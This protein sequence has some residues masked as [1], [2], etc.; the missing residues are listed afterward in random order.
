MVRSPV[1]AGGGPARIQRRQPRLADGLRE[2]GMA[3]RQCGPRP[4]GHRLRAE[5]GNRDRWLRVLGEHP[6]N[7]HARCADFTRGFRQFV[8]FGASHFVHGCWPRLGKADG[9]PAIKRAGPSRSPVRS[10]RNSGACPSA[11]EVSA[12]C[13]CASAAARSSEVTAGLLRPWLSTDRIRLLA[14]RAL[15]HLEL[16]LRVQTDGGPREP[17]DFHCPTGGGAVPFAAC[18]W[19][20]A[21][22]AS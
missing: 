1:E 20:I 12:D 4:G 7:S 5:D 8:W 19:L 3:A 22:R 13:R 2:R 11:Q 6:D 16:G 9:V 10:T 15:R 21:S 14:E 17:R 18:F